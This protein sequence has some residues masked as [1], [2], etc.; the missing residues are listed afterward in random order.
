MLNMNAPKHVLMNDGNV[1]GIVYQSD[2]SGRT[3]A[4]T[5]S[6]FNLNEHLKVFD[7]ITFE[8]ITDIDLLEFFA[9]MIPV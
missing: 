4:F 2:K 1:I 6:E 7:V 5:C 8:R 3:I 9:S